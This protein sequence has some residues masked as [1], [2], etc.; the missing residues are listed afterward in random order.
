MGPNV[1]FGLVGV[2]DVMDGRQNSMLA[3]MIEI[4]V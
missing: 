4:T 3:C 2:G 1:K